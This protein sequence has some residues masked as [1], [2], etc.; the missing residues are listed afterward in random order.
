MRLFFERRKCV[1]NRFLFAG[2]GEQRYDRN[3]DDRK[4]HQQCAGI[5]RR[6]EI[7]RQ[8]CSPLDEIAEAVLEECEDAHMRDSRDHAECEAHP[9]SGLCRLFAEQ[10]PE[11]RAEE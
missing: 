5:D 1:V 9:D 6:C 10:S 11:E 7:E 8:R 4:D 2:L 3:N